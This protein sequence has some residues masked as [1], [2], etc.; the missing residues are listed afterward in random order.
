MRIFFL[1][2][3]LT[4]LASFTCSANA[5]VISEF[6][7]NQPGTDGLQQQI[8]LSGIAGMSFTGFVLGIGGENG[9]FGTVDTVSSVSG[10][11]NSDGLIV[12]TI[13]DLRNPSH[14]I[15][16]VDDYDESAG[17]LDIDLNDDGIADNFGRLM[18]IRDAIG[19]VGG[20]RDSFRLYGEQL[21]GENF[22]F[23]GDSPQLVFRDASIGRWYAINNPSRGK[24]F[25]TDAND[26]AINVM[27]DGD[28]F[29]PSFGSINPSI[30][31]AIPEPNAGLAI[32][33]VT[34]AC[35][36]WRRCRRRRKKAKAA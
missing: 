17:P 32:V 30:V 27:F 2:I 12:S 9:R 23:T 7:P 13:A 16:L 10:T 4:S 35:G 14:T 25:D 15:V 5:A 26:V 11:F 21:G 34:V 18:G 31:T 28:P 3:T 22:A 36:A 8:E 6:S 29:I 1:A 24:V 33:C 19:V 20:A